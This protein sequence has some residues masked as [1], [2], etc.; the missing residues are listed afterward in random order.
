MLGHDPERL[1][2]AHALLFSLPGVPIIRYGDE[3]GM[4]EDLALPGRVAV[5]T[6]MQW[7]RDLNAGFSAAGPLALYRPIVH[8]QP[9]RP[10]DG[11]NVMDQWV[12]PGSLLE[13]IARL[14]RARRQTPEIASNAF[15]VLD[16]G[17]DGLLGVRYPGAGIDTVTLVNITGRPLAG[18][19]KPLE[20][21]AFVGEL[22]ADRRYEPPVAPARVDL[23]PYGYRWFKL[24]P[25]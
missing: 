6:P 9:Y 5:R 8:E 23:G 19:V 3:I 25:G 24:R 1:R 13:C 2:M 14:V 15:E 21:A 18:K 16:T 12:D 22:V 7:S 17:E 10:Q 20:G 11:V 4:G